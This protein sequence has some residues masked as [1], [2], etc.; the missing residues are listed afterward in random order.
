MMMSGKMA[1]LNLMQLA[2]REC[3]QLPLSK[4][5]INSTEEIVPKRGRNPAEAENPLRFVSLPL[6]IRNIFKNGRKWANE[7]VVDVL[8]FEFQ[9]AHFWA[10]QKR[11]W[12]FKELLVSYFR[13]K[14]SRNTKFVFKLWNALK[15]TLHCPAMFTDIGVCWASESVILVDKRKFANFLAVKKATTAISSVQGVF[16]THGFRQIELDP[17]LLPPICSKQWDT[18]TCVFFTRDDGQ[19]TAYSQEANL[20]LVNYRSPARSS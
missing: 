5:T 20:A 12:L 10:T 16:P 2:K 1:I 4:E 3:R 7:F 11:Q 14:P 6:S 15:I 17:K 19:F 18:E 9:P 13:A 8:M